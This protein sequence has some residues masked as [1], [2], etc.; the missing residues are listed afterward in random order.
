MRDIQ[1]RIDRMIIALTACFLVFASVIILPGCN[2]KPATPSNIRPTPSLV[3]TSHPKGNPKPTVSSTP[4][5]SMTTDP[6]DQ[7]FTAQG[8][9]YSVSPDQT[10]W[11]YSSSTLSIEIQ[12]YDD[13][14]KVVCYYVANIRTRGN[15][16]PVLGFGNGNPPGSAEL[17]TTIAD[18]Y[19]A[20]YTQNGDFFSD[21]R[22]PAG[23]V[24]RNGKVYQDQKNADTLAIMPD[25]TLKAYAAGEI[26][27]TGLLATGVKNTYSFGPILISNGV[28]NPNLKKDWVYRDNPRSGI[29]MVEK[30]HYVAI[31]VEGRNPQSS[32]GVTL[33][34]YAKM[35]ADQG[36]VEAY[37]F[38]GGASACMVFMGQPLNAPT[39]VLTT[40][41]YRRV[42]DVIMF[43]HSNAVPIK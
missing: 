35:F 16:K 8:E 43:G 14:A 38:D 42:P 29:G 6:N 25:G 34:E 10:H 18:K 15:E 19:K 37:N 11:S 20:V 2:S 23:V 26:D 12:K 22:N 40:K 9:R 31:V 28:V 17:P 5:P 32:K 4:K 1:F 21:S 36:C 3:Q 41:N 30:G 39:T 13:T 24:I 33:D 7:Y 27:A